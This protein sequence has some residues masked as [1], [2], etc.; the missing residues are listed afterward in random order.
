MLASTETMALGK[1]HGGL[2]QVGPLVNQ[3]MAHG[4]LSRRQAYDV[5]WSLKGKGMVLQSQDVGARGR[6][7]EVLSLTEKAHGLF[8]PYR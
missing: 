3:M 2:V 7:V 1:I 5:L 6:K 8:M 4:S